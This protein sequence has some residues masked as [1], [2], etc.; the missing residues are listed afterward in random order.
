MSFLRPKPLS[1]TNL[2]CVKLQVDKMLKLIEGPI[3]QPKTQS[4]NGFLRPPNQEEQESGHHKH[5]QQEGLQ[6][7]TL[8][9]QLFNGYAS[10]KRLVEAQ[11]VKKYIWIPKQA[12]QNQSTPTKKSMKIPQE[13]LQPKKSHPQH[14]C[15]P[16]SS[17]PKPLETKRV[18]KVWVPRSQAINGKVECKDNSTLDV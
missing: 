2:N 4:L 10:K 5:C 13:L 6:N 3:L 14:I 7:P 9:H 8:N 18:R 1:S 12:I 15:T 11:S 17:E 16:K